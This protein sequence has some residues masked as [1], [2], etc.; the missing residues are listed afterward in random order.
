M[1]YMKTDPRVCSVKSFSVLGSF[2]HKLQ[3]S[4]KSE[5]EAQHTVHLDS[6]CAHPSPVFVTFLVITVGFSNT[7]MICYTWV[8]ILIS[9]VNIYMLLNEI[10]YTMSLLLLE[11]FYLIIQKVSTAHRS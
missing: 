8:I 3:F 9:L 6:V 4:A 2:N 7:D 1:W 10:I 11:T 5:Y